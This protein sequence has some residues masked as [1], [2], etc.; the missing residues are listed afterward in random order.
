[1]G[2]GHA[3]VSHRNGFGTAFDYTHSALESSSLS[4][5]QGKSNSEWKVTV[6]DFASIEQLLTEF[7]SILVPFGEELGAPSAATTAATLTAS[8][9]PFIVLFGLN[10]A[11]LSLRHQIL[12]LGLGIL[13]MVTGILFCN[14]LL[15]GI[16]NRRAANRILRERLRRQQARPKKKPEPEDA[17]SFKSW[18]QLCHG[19]VFWSFRGELSDDVRKAISTLGIHVFSTQCEVRK[20]YLE[21]MKK[22]HPDRFIQNPTEFERA[23]DVAVQVRE[24]YDVLAK[25]FCQVQ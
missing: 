25:Q 2:S 8:I 11:A 4:W 7:L 24:A 14:L 19:T 12:R 18:D 5:V 3:A 6:N 21:L 9:K 16:L 1:M 15:G 23:Q 17:N 20:A 13:E 10:L 22:Y